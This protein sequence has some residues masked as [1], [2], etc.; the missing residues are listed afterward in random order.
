LDWIYQPN[1]VT[2]K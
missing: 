1:G 2:R